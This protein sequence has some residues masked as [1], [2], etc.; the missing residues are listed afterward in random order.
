[1]R[2]PSHDPYYIGRVLEGGVVPAHLD[3]GDHRGH[4]LVDAHLAEVVEQVLLQ[5][6]PDGAL[7]VCSADLERHLVEL[8]TGELR[9]PQDEPHLG[10][11]AVTDGDVPSGL[12]EDCDVVGGGPGGE[13]LVL[14]RRVLRIEDQ[15]VAA[16]GDDCELAIGH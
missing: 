8:T 12:D 9:A 13:V 14:D 3:L 5:R 2:V 4:L 6:V 16:D 7:G 11:V 15:R 1:M 10:A